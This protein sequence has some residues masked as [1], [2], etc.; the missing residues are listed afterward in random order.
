[1]IIKIIEKR[2]DNPPVRLIKGFALAQVIWQ[3]LYVACMCIFNEALAVF[4]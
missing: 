4:Y 3:F 1:M 2:N